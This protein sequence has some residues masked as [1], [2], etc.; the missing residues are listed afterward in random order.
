MLTDSFYIYFSLNLTIAKTVLKHA[1]YLLFGIEDL[2]LQ[3]FQ[4]Q[5]N[6][7]MPFYVNV[8]GLHR[9]SKKGT[10]ML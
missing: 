1:Y 10:P 7:R 9:V 8:L 6:S 3:E 4:T 5:A 2:L